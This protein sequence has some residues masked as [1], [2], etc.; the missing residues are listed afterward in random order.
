MWKQLEQRRPS[1][2][3]RTYSGQESL[4][5]GLRRDMAM[6]LT[7]IGSTTKRVGL[8]VKFERHISNLGCIKIRKLVS[9]FS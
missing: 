9:M 3:P 5:P 4:G 8:R 1:K 6:P 2:S 7:D